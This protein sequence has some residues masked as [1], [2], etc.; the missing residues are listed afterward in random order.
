MS[1]SN[2]LFGVLA[3]LAVLCVVGVIVL[4]VLEI[5]FYAAPTSLWP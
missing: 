5:N 1:S 4:Q 3:L 2:N